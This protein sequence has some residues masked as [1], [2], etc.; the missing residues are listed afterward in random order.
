MRINENTKGY[1]GLKIL[2][3]YRANEMLSTAMHGNNK[4]RYR[5]LNM[6]G[7]VGHLWKRML[8]TENS[9]IYSRELHGR[10]V[11]SYEIND[12]TMT[13][14]YYPTRQH[15]QKTYLETSATKHTTN[16]KGIRLEI[17]NK[18]SKFRLK[19]RLQCIQ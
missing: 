6:S 7:S 11:G 9:K 1:T 16:R 8:K 17:G 13:R 2:C 12:Y 14:R 18:T 10:F 19:P 3:P 4:N 5:L 15:G